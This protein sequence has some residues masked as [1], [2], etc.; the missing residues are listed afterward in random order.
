MLGLA[1]CG[2]PDLPRHGAVTPDP[3]FYQ[4]HIE[5]ILIQ[6]CA[7][8][9]SGCHS[10]NADDPYRLAAGNLDVTSFERLQLRRDV[11]VPFGAYAYPLLL[12]K[13]VPTGA[14]QLFYDTKVPGIDPKISPFR[15][16]EIQHSGGPI[17]SLDS[18][19]YATLQRWLDDGASETGTRPM[20][21]PR[22]GTGACSHG[23]PPGF[24]PSAF[25]NPTTQLS[26]AAFKS[27]VQPVLAQHGCTAGTCHGAPQADF[28]L[29][30]GDGDAELAFNFSQAWSFVTAPAEDSE[31]VRVPLAVASGGRGHTGGDQLAGGNDPG[32]VAMRAWAQQI[33]PRGFG[34]GDPG[35]EFFAS[36]VQ[37]IL[38][39]RGCALAAC[40]S[41]AATNDFKLRSG[42]PGFFAAVALEK[43]Y[44]L[45]RNQFMAIEF[46]DARRGRAVAKGLISHGSAA[47]GI[48]HRGGPVLE[49]P[50]KPAVCAAFLPLN[51]GASSPLCT[52]QEWVNRERAA[53]A[54][55]LTDMGDGKPA[56]LVYVERPLAA[57]DADR[58]AFDTFA[59]GATLRKVATTFNAGT[60]VPVAAGTSVQMDGCGLGAVDIRTPDVAPDGDRVVFAAR[61]LAS[62]ALQVY[63]TKLSDNTACVPVTVAAPDNMGVKAHNF[64]PVFSPDGKWIVFASTR[65]KP[66]V[67]ATRSRKRLLPQSDLWRVAIT[68][69]A[70]NQGSYE[71]ITVLSNAELGPHF[72][73]EGRITM[74]TEKAS[75]GF[76]Q[77]SGRRI[78][79]DR[80]DYH[81][82][83]AQRASSPYAD[84][85]DPTQTRPSIGYASASDIREASD[86]NFLVILSDLKPDGSPVAPGGG[87]ALGIFNRSL[88]PF[89]QGRS[90]TG[91]LRALRV[92][93]AAAASGRAGAAAS[94]RAP[95]SLPSGEILVS[96]ASS[97]SAGNFEIVAL[98]PRTEQRTPLILGAPAGTIRVDAVL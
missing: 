22:A 42:A 35:R 16:L 95:M 66:A 2:Y 39:A 97:A 43:N 65:G 51:P 34:G 4:Q 68:G 47:N 52:I 12:I 93:D 71:Q 53:A 54:G 48:T 94:Y 70:V 89:E 33:G 83:L 6:K 72:M 77:L 40:H 79:W 17:L 23:I 11:L 31:L 37:P 1:A 45:V 57:L 46:P 29:T 62:E 69:D 74:T 73:R 28:Y 32:Y 41:P 5:P 44:Q 60:V 26:F 76:Y 78:N 75:D 85:T 21:P 25:V 13:A 20:T 27:T 36:Y 61:K 8:N 56:T 63:M 59:G 14:L 38:L 24:D 55:Q 88:G 58:L 87:G 80:T 19:A 49:A 15:P 81:P 9:T 86:G 10:T 30:C 84:P 98:D 67:G 18:E 64:N 90:D 3:T 50:D 96:Y 92:V 91:Y 7:G 82:L